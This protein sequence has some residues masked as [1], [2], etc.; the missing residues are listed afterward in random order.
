MSVQ[1]LFTG[2][3][4]VIDDDFDVEHSE[5][6][7]ITAAIRNEGGQVLG[8]TALPP[9]G[10]QFVNFAG[11]A[12]FILDWNLRGRE[13][14]HDDAGLPIQIPDA[15]KE[16]DLIEKV[17]FLTELRASRLAP[18]F[19][20]TAE[21]VGH[22]EE[23][24]RAHED[25]YPT[26]G[27]SHIFVRRKSDVLAEGVFQVLNDWVN[28]NP[29]ALALKMW[30]QS[31]EKAKND[32][33]LDFYNKST[34]WPAILWRTFDKDKV[35][36]SDELGRL[37]SRNLISRMLPITIDM[38][39]FMENL[40]QVINADRD[41]YRKMLLDVLEGERFIKKAGLHDDSIAPG[42]V[43]RE[44]S[45][46]YWLNIRPDCDCIC[47]NGEEVELYLLKGSP[48][49]DKDMVKE[50]RAEAGIFAERDDQALVFGMHEGKSIRFKL[51]DVY[52]KNWSEMKDKRIGR[53][54]PPFI[55]RIQ[56]RYASY[57]QRPGLPK[58]PLEAMPQ[59]VIDYLAQERAK[60]EAANEPVAA[61]EGGEQA[62]KA[63][64]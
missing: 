17:R 6:H 16:Q 33:F 11:A 51:Q 19:I 15:I 46:T 39:S 55:T 44:N 23:T 64:G 59:T 22:V 24:L 63:N 62:A 52:Q 43:F 36:A 48:I 2:I 27:T 12:F 30:E 45:T 18:V 3:A 25:L 8:M 50:L 53:L 34:L 38:S 20:F 40:D 41:A 9:D 54:L 31:Y 28:A 7:Q 4:V 61:K 58:I 35:P 32:L 56:Q 37:I 21:D 1:G 5:I 57:L 14:G 29:S 60:E 47:R 26:N 13:F 49:K 10:T 42:D